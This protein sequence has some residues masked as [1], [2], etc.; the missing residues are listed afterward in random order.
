MEYLHGLNIVVGDRGKASLS[1]FGKTVSEI[2][3]DVGPAHVLAQG[4]LVSSD[5]K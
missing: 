2:P 5:D 3:L 1:E 4:L